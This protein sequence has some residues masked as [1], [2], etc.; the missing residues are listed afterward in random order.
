MKR[1]SLVLAGTFW[2]VSLGVALSIRRLR[3]GSGDPA[4][5][6][7]GVPVAGSIY[8]LQATWTSDLGAPWQLAQ[9]AGRYLIVALIFTRCPGICPT[10]VKQLQAVDRRMSEGVR[11][12][13]HFALFSVDPK[14]DTPAVLHAYRERMG[15][16]AGHWTLGTAPIDT[17]RE[18][19]A[20]LGF[21]FSEQQDGLP[22]HSKLVTLLDRAGKPMLQRADIGVDPEL[23]T[24]TIEA[25]LR[26]EAER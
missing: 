4:I 9:L 22:T 25:A 15:L 13:T 7:G 24:R 3:A 8:G 17:V 26:A 5:P 1:R 12:Q 21:S 10:L 11:A 14:H 2:T 18:L 6:G 20:T 16:A 19:G 23:L